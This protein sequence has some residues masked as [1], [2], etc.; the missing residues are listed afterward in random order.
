MLSVRIASQRTTTVGAFSMDKDT[1]KEVGGAVVLWAI[2]IG[3]T[4]FGL[5]L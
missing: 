4:L 2:I 5:S 1:L 3:I